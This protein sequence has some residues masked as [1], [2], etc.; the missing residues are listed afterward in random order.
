MLF[1]G[2]RLTE[3]SDITNLTVE[4]GASFPGDGNIGELFFKTSAT[5]GL[6][7]HDGITWTRVSI[8]SDVTTFSI[9]GDVSGTV[10]GGTDVLTLATVNSNVGT[11]GDAASTVTVTVNA[12]GLITA[13][14]SNSIQIAETQITNGALL[15]RVADNETIS[16]T[17]AFNNA[18]TGQTPSSGSHLATK[19]YVDNI[20]AGI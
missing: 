12:K 9:T 6:Y 11:F 13:I 19:D 5:S 2:I 14:S 20:A 15:A 3:L 7:I 16:G 8:G 10:D 18:V 17:W 4:A 1:D